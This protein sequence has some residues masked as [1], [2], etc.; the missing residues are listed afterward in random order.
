LNKFIFLYIFFF[1]LDLIRN[2]VRQ[3]LQFVPTATFDKST[4]A[5]SALIS[6]IQAL[7][8]TKDWDQ[9]AS[10]QFVEITNELRRLDKV[11]LDLFKGNTGLK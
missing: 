9:F 2:S 1:L 4:E 6:K 11:N 8:K 5:V 3:T 10:A 7:L